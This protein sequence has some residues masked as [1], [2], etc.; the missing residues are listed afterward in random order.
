MAPVL[1]ATL[2]GR[3]RIASPDGQE[4]TPKSSK[5]QGLL[6]LLLTA[7]D[8]VR[9]RAWLQDRL[10]SD[11]GQEQGARS[12]R[13]EVSQIR[14]TL[15]P[16]ADVIASDRK[17]VRLD[18]QC[19]QIEAADTDPTAQF[20]EGMD[21]RDDEFNA[22]LS[23]ERNRRDATMEA[24]FALVQ[25]TQSLALIGLSAANAASKVLEAQVMD[26]ARKTLNDLCEVQIYRQVPPSLKA[27]AF[28]AGVQVF[29][30]PGQNLSLRITLERVT[31]AATVWSETLNGI[32]LEDPTELDI[33]CLQSIN[34]LFEK[35]CDLFVRGPGR[36]RSPNA[37]A[38]LAIMKTFTIEDDQLRE[39]DHLL[40][41]A[42]ELDPRG[43][44]LAWRA[45]IRTIQ[46][47]ERFLQD[48]QAARQEG[49]RFCVEALRLDAT[50][51]NVLAACAN[52]RTIV[53]RNVSGGLELARLSVRANAANPLAWW[54]LSNAVQYTGDEKQAYFAALR[55]CQL[56]IGTKL[57]F[58]TAFQ[59]SLTA[60]LL[61]REDEARALG[62]K[63][64]AL[65]PD[66]KPPL[67]YLTVLYASSGDLENGSRVFTALAEKEADFSAERLIHDPEY[68]VRL[69]RN[70]GLLDPEKLHKL[71]E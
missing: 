23:V 48:G 69:M 20:L 50:N 24:G 30:V 58:W 71:Q 6:A 9:G 29:E 26:Q 12:L 35:L 27:H 64:S 10:W 31:D 25:P 63:A 55:A 70:S 52:F 62:E 2:H 22:W 59:R 32:S 5:G 46:F 60:M 51:S 38:A 7:P 28:I 36:P 1:K 53:Q 54:A 43:S 37:L 13:Q 65:S 68:P 45:Q 66:F 61:G 34:R 19:V 41:Q 14:K 44:F 15:G 33:A 16:Y 39:A 42:F 57:E 56:T 40:A 8:M 17:T 47:V 3:F 67:R 4:L 18:P 11:R 49:E 21:I